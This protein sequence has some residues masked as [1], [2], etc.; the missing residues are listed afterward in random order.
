M[1]PLRFPFNR[2]EYRHVLLARAGLW[3]VVERT[4]I[5]DGRPHLPHYEVVQLQRAPA[6]RWPDGRETPAHEAYPPPSRWGR[7]GW[8]EPTLKHA[9][10]RWEKI[11]AAAHHAHLPT[12][13]GL[14]IPDDEEGYRAWKEGR[15]PCRMASAPSNGILRGHP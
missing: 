11:R 5:G 14:G 3:C 4:W 6:K 9:R 10:A 15:L 2:D 13:A 8:S 12:W 1:T 7:D